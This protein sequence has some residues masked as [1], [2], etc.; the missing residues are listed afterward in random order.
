MCHSAI[1]QWLTVSDLNQ[2]VPE[3]ENERADLFSHLFLSWNIHTNR[4]TGWIRLIM[5]TVPA[6]TGAVSRKGQLVCLPTNRDVILYVTIHTVWDCVIG[7]VALCSVGVVLDC[8][9]NECGVTSVLVCVKGKVHPILSSFVHPQ[10]CSKTLFLLWTINRNA[11]K[12]VHVAFFFEKAHSEQKCSNW[13]QRC[14]KF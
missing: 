12:R 3:R 10:C 13:P 6:D 4:L 7:C 2:R 9:G 1:P 11:L 8:L 5:F 14:H